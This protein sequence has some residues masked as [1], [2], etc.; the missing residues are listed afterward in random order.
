MLGRRRR[1]PSR[2]V[3]T[4]EPAQTGAVHR[5]KLAVL[6]LPAALVAACA[7]APGP[8]PADLA[9]TSGASAPSDPAATQ[10]QADARAAADRLVEAVALPPGAARTTTGPAVLDGPAMGTPSTSQLVD[11]TAYFSV[12][13]SATQARAWFEAHPQPGLVATGTSSAGASTPLPATYGF[14]YASGSATT[15]GIAD[16]E[17]GVTAQGSDAAIRVD[18]VAQWIDPAPVRVTPSGQATKVTIAAGCPDTDRGIAVVNPDSPDLDGRMLPDTSPTSAMTCTYDGLNGKDFSLVDSEVLDAAH[19]VALA[20]RIQGL[21]LGSRGIGAHSCP[22]D[23]GRARI[24]V[25][26]Y[27]GRADVG[28]W[29]LTSGCRYTTNGHIRADGT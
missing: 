1:G 14:G 13:M 17:I 9:G 24:V 20:A 26:G 18:G 2:L 11:S 12:P 28:I 16:L 7:S 4:P 29:Q 23:D 5:V 6:T 21:P 25:F 8:A 3:A 27:D 15:W 19:A 10:N 22:A